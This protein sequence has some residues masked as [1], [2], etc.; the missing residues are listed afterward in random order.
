MSHFLSPLFLKASIYLEEPIHFKGGTPLEIWK[1]RGPTNQATSYRG[2]L[3][4]SHV[5]KVL[6]NTY[7]EPTLQYH[8]ASADPLQYGGT[9]GRGVDA[10]SHELRLF[11][12]AYQQKKESCA[13]F[14]L[15]IKS[16]YYRLLHKLAIDKT[17]SYNQ[18]L[19]L[20]KTLGLPEE[21]QYW[22][23]QA[24][25]QPNA[26]EAA[27]CPEWLRA[28]G[29]NFH[30]CTWY[31]TRGDTTT[32]ATLRGTRPGDGYAD[33]L[34]NVVLSQ[35]LKDIA[36]TLVESGLNITYTWNGIRSFAGASQGDCVTK[37]LNVVW[38]DDIAV[39]IKHGQAAQLHEALPIIIATYIDRLATRGLL[40]NFGPGKSEVILM[41]RGP[42][43]VALR[44]QLFSVEEPVIPVQTDFMGTFDIRL[45]LKYKHLGVT[46]HGN[47]YMTTELRL[48][49]TQA[50]SAFNQYRA[51]VYQNRKLGLTK[52][53]AIFRSCAL[54]ILFWN[55]GTW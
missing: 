48:R 11:F 16:A 8:L 42:G 5:A 13:I 26:L 36:N 49:V 46:I 30:T 37:A 29:A 34:F 10:A 3:V 6:H 17:C 15:D 24:L 9:P 35:V 51:A 4:S 44:R 23:V 21:A 41:L 33:L 50:H 31:Q 25:H 53:V 1:G 2:I 54:S 40:L 47:G 12:R 18:G 19:R 14:Y 55:S 52:R 45:V 39:M 20:L 38:A 27:G 22:L 32:M 28:I 7:R 43:S